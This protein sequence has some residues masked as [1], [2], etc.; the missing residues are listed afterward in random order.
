MD[1][2]DIQAFCKVR[3]DLADK[4]LSDF[5]PTSAGGLFVYMNGRQAPDAATANE[6]EARENEQLTRQKQMAAFYEW[7]RIRRDAA[8][9]EIAQR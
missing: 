4:Q 2:P 6:A 8:R 9:L 5:I 1:M 7:M 3:W